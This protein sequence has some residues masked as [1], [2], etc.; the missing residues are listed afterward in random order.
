MHIPMSVLERIQ[1]D[2]PCKKQKEV[3]ELLAS[4]GRESY[5]QEHERVLMDILKL[6]KGDIKQVEELVAR[7][8]NDYRDIIFWAEYP[9]ESKLDTAE[10]KRI[11]TRCSASSVQIGKSRSKTDSHP[12]YANTTP[13]CTQNIYHHT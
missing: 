6:A 12:Q 13:C 7:A 9:E 10:K 2:Y 4:Y 8:K 5:Q 3:E 11:S 1:Q